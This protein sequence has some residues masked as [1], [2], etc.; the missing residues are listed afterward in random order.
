MF[1]LNDKPV[2]ID[3]TF[4]FTKDNYDTP[5]VLEIKALNN[6]VHDGDLTRLID[7]STQSLDNDFDGLSVPSIETHLIDDDE[8][9]AS[10]RPVLDATEHQESG[11]FEIVFNTPLPN[12][13]GDPDI[14][15]NYEVVSVELDSGIK[16]ILDPNLSPTD[17]VDLISQS[18]TKSTHKLT[19]P[20]GGS[21][22]SGFVV[23]IDNVVAQAKDNLIVIKLLDGEG[24]ELDKNNNS[25]TIKFIDN[26]EAGVVLMT[27]GIPR[28]TENG[29]ESEF[30]LA[31]ATQPTSDV[32]V[33]LREV[34]PMIVIN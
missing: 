18:P 8:P 25:A 32:K 7:V 21:K 31:L 17:L 33:D 13:P 2:G 24:Y 4:T 5:Q 22:A 19:I 14:A 28:V 11:V 30:L 10:I 16:G 6:D 23:P 20:R 3:H 34:P 12:Q 9:I 29:G 26:D 27:S 1:Y 15:V